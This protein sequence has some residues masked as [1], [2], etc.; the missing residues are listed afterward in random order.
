VHEWSSYLDERPALC[1]SYLWRSIFVV[2]EV[3]GM[4]GELF[5][6]VTAAGLLMKLVAYTDRESRFKKQQVNAP[7]Y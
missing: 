7:R 6:M 5:V 4:I 1:V 2:V 3:A